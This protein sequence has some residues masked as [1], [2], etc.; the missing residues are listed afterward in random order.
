M[1][2]ENEDVCQDKTAL[3]EQLLSMEMDESDKRLRDW[4][5]LLFISLQMALYTLSTPGSPE[6][7]VRTFVSQTNQ[8]DS[9]R[10]GA[11]G[12]LESAQTRRENE[13]KRTPYK[14]RFHPVHER[15]SIP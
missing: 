14:A 3:G 6:K 8:S 7:R 15:S 2:T 12:Y 4:T 5:Y 13:R 11:A 10:S 9:I 1:R